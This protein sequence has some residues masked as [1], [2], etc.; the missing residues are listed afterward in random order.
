MRLVLDARTAAFASL[1]D[2]AGVFPPAS[3]SMAEAVDTYR[4]LR[5]S[6]DRW[7]IG[8]FLCRASDLESLAAVATAAMTRGEPPWSIGVIADMS[9]G[10]A[11]SIA[12]EF[13][14]EMSPVMEVGAAEVRIG[15]VDDAGAHVDA[16]STIDPDVATFIEID[17]SEGV[18]PQLRAIVAALRDRGRTGGA[19]IRCG[20]ESADLFP[21]TERLAEFVWEASLAAVPFKATAGLHQPIRH[22]DEDPGVYRHGFVNL[23]L[24]SVAADQGESRHTIEDIVAEVDPDAFTFGAAAITWRNIVFPGS[25]IRRS[26]TR[27]FLAFGSC[28]AHEPIEAMRSHAMLG[29]GT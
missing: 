24:A 19:K 25:A 1:V 18:A 13:H 6:H 20:G 22:H 4:R 28:D 23:L 3:L 8:R 29:E 14:R 11:A 27:G 21:S 10:A 12:H 17:A 15:S 2:Y 5:S 16:I 7:V 9:A 26:R